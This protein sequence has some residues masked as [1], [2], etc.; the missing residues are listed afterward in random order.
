MSSCSPCCGL[1]KAQ[2]QTTPALRR[3]NQKAR[4]NLSAINRYLLMHCEWCIDLSYNSASKVR[5]SKVGSATVVSRLVDIG[6]VALCCLCARSESK[7]DAVHEH[8]L[9]VQW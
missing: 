8:V 9:A 1:K 3:K 2:P 6:S 7:L 5:V 4:G